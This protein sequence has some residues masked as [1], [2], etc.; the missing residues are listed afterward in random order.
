MEMSP[1]TKFLYLKE[2]LVPKV[3]MLIDSLPYTN[4]SYAIAKSVLSTKFEKPVK[5][6][7]SQ[8]QFIT[9]LPVAPD[10]NSNRVHE[11]FVKLTRNVYALD[12]MDKLRDIKR[13]VRLCSGYAGQVTKNQGRSGQFR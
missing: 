7:A 1:R 9:S 3:R 12:A 8:M 10:A 6:P 11:A 5:V 13:Y 2:L 4:E